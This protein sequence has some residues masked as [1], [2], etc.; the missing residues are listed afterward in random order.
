MGTGTYL[1]SALIFKGYEVHEF[2]PQSMGKY[3]MQNQNQGKL[4][5]WSKKER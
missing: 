3:K 1:C 4:Y 2:L 5:I